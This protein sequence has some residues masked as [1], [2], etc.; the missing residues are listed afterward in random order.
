MTLRIPKSLNKSDGDIGDDWIYRTHR[1]GIPETGPKILFKVGKYRS[2]ETFLGFDWVW[3][4]MSVT[5]VD[6]EG[7]VKVNLK[8]IEEEKCW[9]WFQRIIELTMKDRIPLLRYI[10]LDFRDGTFF[11]TDNIPE[12]WRDLGDLSVYLPPKG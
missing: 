1:L 2:R 3:D 6:M 10:I 12:G 11:D 5:F 9:L 7:D 8:D 4:G